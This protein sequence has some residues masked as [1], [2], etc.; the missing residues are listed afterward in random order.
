[1]NRSYLVRTEPI[2]SASPQVWIYI[3]LVVGLVYVVNSLLLSRVFAK[4]GREAWRAWVPFLNYW[5]FLR[6]GGVNG[7]HTLWLIGAIVAYGLAWIVSNLEMELTL[8][9]VAIGLLAVFLVTYTMAG[10]K[11]QRQ[12]AK[13]WGFI[14][15]LF[16]NVFAPVWLWILAL[17]RSRWVGKKL[18][19]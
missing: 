13:P 16:V 9:A 19:G 2:D 8:C 3:G 18:K 12:L 6:I 11:I 1:M 4:A 10:L 14:F 5:E 15:L 7:V 17:D